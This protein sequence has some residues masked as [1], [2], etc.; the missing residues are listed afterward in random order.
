MTFAIQV[1]RQA[2]P[3]QRPRPQ[4]WQSSYRRVAYFVLALAFTLPLGFVAVAI[5]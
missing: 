4:W 2:R 1:G 3:G 5:W